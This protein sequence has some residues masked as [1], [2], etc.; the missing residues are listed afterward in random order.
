MTY[1]SLIDDQTGSL[2]GTGRNSESLE[3]LFWEKMDYHSI[4]EEIDEDTGEPI[5][6]D[7]MYHKT[8]EGMVEA[9][10][11]FGFHI[12]KHDKEIPDTDFDTDTKNWDEISLNDL[13][14]EQAVEEFKK[15]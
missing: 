1:Y 5:P 6:F 2:M 15:Q 7:K 4:D 3:D 13:S 11:D 9:C 8:I 10:F 12:V 14:Y